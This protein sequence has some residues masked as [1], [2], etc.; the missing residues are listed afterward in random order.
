M[1]LSYI[2][3]NARCQ[4]GKGTMGRFNELQKVLIDN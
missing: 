2:R 1:I 4:K 3:F